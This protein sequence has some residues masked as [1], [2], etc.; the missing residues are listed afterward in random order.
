MEAFRY[1]TT[2]S[3][4]KRKRTKIIFYFGFLAGMLAIIGIAYV[5]LYAP[6]TKV[7]GFSVDG[8]TRLAE[9][10]VLKIAKTAALSHALARFLGVDNILAWRNE[11]VD[12]GSSPIAQASVKVDLLKRSVAISVKE[13]ERFAVWCASIKDATQ[14]S[15]EECYWFDRDGV[16]FEKAP[17]TEGSLIMTVH[18]LERG[19]AGIGTTITNQEYA[20][21]IVAAII[22]LQDIGVKAEDIMFTKSH[23]EL[24]VRSYNNQW[25]PLLISTRFDPT[26]NLKS[27]AALA[28][29]VEITKADY[30]DLRVEN[31]IFYKNH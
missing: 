6:F 29:S 21:N 28:G 13:R 16:I 7:K 12:F 10:S 9:A 25:P 18:D 20:R 1:T 5:I 17:N 15:E 31:K 22:G 30:I 26:T 11:E 19:S 27:L 23:E 4:Q 8:N 24:E 14:V 3:A 2:S